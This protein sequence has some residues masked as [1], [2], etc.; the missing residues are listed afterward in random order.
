MANL[1]KLREA[2]LMVCDAL[3]PEYYELGVRTR[4]GEYS[5]EVDDIVWT[6]AQS[7]QLPTLE[8]AEAQFL[9]TP[10]VETALQYWECAICTPGVEGGE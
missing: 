3:F 7:K 10:T 8:S 2:Q 5:G 4:P 6:G 9:S 1:I